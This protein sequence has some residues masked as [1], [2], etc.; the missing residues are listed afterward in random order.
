MVGY[1]GLSFSS[2]YTFIVESKAN[3]WDS[4]CG[5]IYVPQKRVGATKESESRQ[6]ASL[7]MLCCS[8]IQ[9]ELWLV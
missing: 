3:G 6:V 8:A 4:N 7:I 5:F 9:F 2:V 1:L